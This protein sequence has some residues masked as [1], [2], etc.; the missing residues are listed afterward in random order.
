[1][2]DFGLREKGQEE[3]ALGERL[4]AQQEPTNQRT[5]SPAVAKEVISCTICLDLSSHVCRG[6]P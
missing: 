6:Q 2:T 5:F 3:K 4:I 1:M